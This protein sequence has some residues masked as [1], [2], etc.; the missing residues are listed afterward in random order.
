MAAKDHLNVNQSGRFLIVHRGLAGVHHNELDMKKRLG[1]HWSEKEHVAHQFATERLES[2]PEYPE[3][4]K[5]TV[6]HAFVHKRHILDPEKDVDDWNDWAN[7]D[8]RY[9]E[10]EGEVPLRPNTPV[11]IFGATD[12]Y[13]DKEVPHT[14]KRRIGRL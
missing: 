10:H 12:Q 5:G 6:L 13:Y 14:F 4:E 1:T 11:H 2:D 8:D 3:E 9:V 7:S